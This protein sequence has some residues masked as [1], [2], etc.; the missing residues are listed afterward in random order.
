MNTN[1]SVAVNKSDQIFGVIAKK[2]EGWLGQQNNALPSDLN[3][4]RF[5]ANCIAMLRSVKGIEKCAPD[6]ICR[7]LMQGAYLGLDF[8]NG[9]CYA[10]PYSN[11]LRFQ[12]DY[13]GE[14]K[15][16]KKYSKPAIRHIYADLVREGDDFENGVLNGNQFLNHKKKPLNNG[17]IL[18]VYAVANFA[19]GTSHYEV[20]TSEEVKDI[21]NKYSKAEKAWRD[22]EGEMYKKTALRRLCKH[23]TF[24]FESPSAQM[25]W[26]EGAAVDFNKKQTYQ[27][28]SSLDNEA[29][30]VT[31]EV[32]EASDGTY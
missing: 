12:T 24:D 13:K 10:I 15:L 16:A 7:T 22:S 25:A 14:I 30:D 19:N 6:T 20:L 9:E 3:K 32:R 27:A 8:L 17:T 18:G 26:D 23:L 2:L 1:Q 11:E 29:I 5:K 31:G 21:K 28:A 4:E